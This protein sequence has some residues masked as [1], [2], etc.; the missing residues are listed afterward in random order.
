MEL[1]AQ[2]E[3]AG[4]EDHVVPFKDAAQPGS[5]L[6]VGHLLRVI[7]GVAEGI[8]D[9]GKGQRRVGGHDLVRRHP[10]FEPTGD[11]PD[12]DAR[13]FDP[14]L[15]AEGVGALDD[16]GA[17]G[18]LDRGA[19]GRF[20]RGCHGGHSGGVHSHSMVAGGLEETS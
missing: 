16:V 18:P 20:G 4:D 5:L 13:V 10:A 12:G 17:L 6:V 1:L 3:P 7:V 15:A 14:G 9:L 11:V 19:G 8:V 2:D